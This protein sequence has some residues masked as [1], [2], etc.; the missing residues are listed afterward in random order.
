MASSTEYLADAAWKSFDQEAYATFDRGELAASILLFENLATNYPERG[1]YE[2]MLG[3]A[4]KYRRD[5]LACIRHNQR[6]I[7]EASPDSSIEGERWNIAIAATAL[8]DWALAREQWIACGMTLEPGDA[9]LDAERGVVSVRLNAWN[10]GETLFAQRIGLARGRLI[11]I[12]LP[13]SG[14]RLNDIVLLDGAKT[15]ERRYGDA[16]VP[17]LNALQRLQPSDLRTFEVRVDCAS[18]ADADALEGATGPGIGG[19]EDWS[20]SMTFLCKA[21]SYGVPHKHAERAPD[22][23]GWVRERRMGIA[24]QSRAAVDALLDAWVAEGRSGVFLERLAKRRPRRAVLEVDEDEF[25]APELVEGEKW[26][27]QPPSGEA[28]GPS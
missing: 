7:A 9:P 24:A 23:T 15:G 25:E 1:Y 10:G 11:N 18:L 19:I 12:P 3:L 26:W 5:W 4:H 13:D 16:T 2:Y 22:D 17:V 6:A 14:H 20:R 21:C 28:A 8:G 27:M